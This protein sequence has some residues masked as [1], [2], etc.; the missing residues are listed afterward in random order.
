LVL[1]L[2]CDYR[3]GCEGDYRIGLNEVAIGASFPRVALEI[4]RLRLPHARAAE[5]ALGAALYPA[6]QAVR[7]RGVHRLLPPPGLCAG[8]GPAWAGS[9]VR[10]TPTRRRRSSRMRWLPCS[11]RRP[12]R[13]PPEQPCGRLPRVAWRGQR[14][15]RSSRATESSR[16]QSLAARDDSTPPT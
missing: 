7:L 9:R 4:V 14:N 12:R 11:R 6:S 2:A 1:A 15:A 10:P 5:L 3:L 8:A 13:K 16:G